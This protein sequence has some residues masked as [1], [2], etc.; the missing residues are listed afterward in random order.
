MDNK[1]LWI[2]GGTLLLG[3][4]AY[5]TMKP[6]DNFITNFQ[7]EVINTSVDFKNADIGNK[8]V[9]VLVTTSLKNS[10]A[11]SPKIE[12]IVVIVSTKDKNGNWNSIFTSDPSSPFV[13]NPR[14]ITNKTIKFSL[15]LLSIGMDLIELGKK[16]IMGKKTEFMFTV[17]TN[18]MGTILTEKIFKEF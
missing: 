8:T 12:S 17:N 7:A 4:V 1:K 18:V 13:V 10:E 14:S 5:Q 16:A 15:P 9:P 2:I 11:F 6:V 3:F